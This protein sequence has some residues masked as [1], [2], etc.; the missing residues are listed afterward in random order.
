MPTIE[1]KKLGIITV[2]LSD[3]I[4]PS[5]EKVYKDYFKKVKKL[6]E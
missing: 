5:R 1:T 2:D 4:A 6:L 3:V